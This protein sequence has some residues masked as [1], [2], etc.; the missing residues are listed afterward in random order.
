[1]LGELVRSVNYNPRNV[2]IR[3]ERN[4]TLH[5]KGSG[6]KLELTVEVKE[7]KEN[8]QNSDSS[9]SSGSSQS[10]SSSE[11]SEAS[12]NSNDKSGDEDNEENE[13]KLYEQLLK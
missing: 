13:E 8:K 7:S 5:A 4:F 3:S 9:S 6:D 10:E 12:D 1:M 2:A 11:I